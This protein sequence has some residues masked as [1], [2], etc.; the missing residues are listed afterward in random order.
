MKTSID[1]PYIQSRI[2][3]VSY[4]VLPGTTCTICNITMVNG[5]GVRG[6]S[7]CVDPKNFDAAIGR[8]IAYENAFQKLWQLEGYLLAERVSN[9][10]EKEP[11]AEEVFTKVFYTDYTLRDF[12]EELKVLDA[13][14]CRRPS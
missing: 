3:D 2:K 12:I 5:F 4:T 9:R 11:T 1:K 7:A 14:L 8:D 10:T 6:E 13:Q